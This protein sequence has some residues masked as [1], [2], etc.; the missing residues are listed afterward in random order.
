[1]LT[2]KI[3]MSKS[4]LS[5]RMNRSELTGCFHSA[6]MAQSPLDIYGSESISG[7]KPNNILPQGIGVSIHKD[8]QAFE[9]SNIFENNSQIQRSSAFGFQGE[10]MKK[11]LCKAVFTKV[12]PDGFRPNSHEIILK[13]ARCK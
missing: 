8:L 7:N 4:N 2:M 10:I 11:V 3:L 13:K 1:V 6:I 5:D 12:L 9:Q